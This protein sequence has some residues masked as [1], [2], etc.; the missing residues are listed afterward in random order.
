[1]WE[2]TIDETGLINMGSLNPY[3]MPDGRI[4]VLRIYEKYPDMPLSAVMEADRNIFKEQIIEFERE[5]LILTENGEITGTFPM[6]PNLMSFAMCGNGILSVSRAEG[7]EYGDPG[8][9]RLTLLNWDGTKQWQQTLAEVYFSVTMC[10]ALDDGLILA[11]FTGIGENAKSL[12]RKLDVLGNVEWSYEYPSVNTQI[13]DMMVTHEG[14]IILCGFVISGDSIEPITEP[15]YG[16]VECISGKGE[17][18]WRKEMHELGADVYLD[19]M[20]QTGNTYQILGRISYS[21]DRIVSA[22]IEADYSGE[23]LRTEYC[24]LLDIEHYYI[25]GYLKQNESDIWLYGSKSNKKDGSY[26]YLYSFYVPL[27]VFPAVDDAK[28]MFVEQR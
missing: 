9:I 18:L 26:A 1:L 17:R 22:K 4:L 2:R 27:S 7:L 5:L 25:T 3:I 28:L 21:N 23:F 15:P 13:K 10:S 11:G 6:P 16:F 12:I 20:I 14:N 24:S 8:S 19:S